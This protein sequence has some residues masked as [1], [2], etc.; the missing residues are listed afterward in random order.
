MRKDGRKPNELRPIRIVRD[1]LQHPE[2][3]CLVEFGN[4]KVICTVSVQDGVPPFLKGKGQGWIT[5][6]YAML[7]RAT[8]TRNIRE[9]VQ[10]RISG[11]TH[12]IQRMIGRAMRTALDLT[13]VGERTFWIDCDVIQAD[14]GTRTASITGAFV[15]LADAVIKLYNEGIL[16][17]TPIKDF[18]ASV[19]VGIVEGQILLDLNYEEDSSAKVDMNVVATGTG[20]ISEIQA[21]GEENTFT[22][23]EFDKMLSL[24]L[25]GISQ[26]VELQKAFYEIN[27]GIW[28]KKNI[29]EAR[30]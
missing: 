7:P 10:G 18:V 24:A 20:S 16:I 19:S 25:D 11:R 4:T 29:K 28:R 15:A 5:A 8:A 22:R 2:G 6:E 26:L 12:E 27:A 1:Y 23:D 13:K 3:S 17:S 9:S 21:L 14:G 30:L